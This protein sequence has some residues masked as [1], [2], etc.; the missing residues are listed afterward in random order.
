MP[1]DSTG[2]IKHLNDIALVFK[3]L[4]DIAQVCLCMRI[5]THWSCNLVLSNHWSC[6]VHVRATFI[7]AI[8][9]AW[10]RKAAVASGGSIDGDEV[11]DPNETPE[12]K[13]E[14]ERVRRQAN[15]SRERFVVDY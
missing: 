2:K 4:N 6:L 12:Q 11:I 8:W 15:N 9:F 3:H 14:R 7:Y 1:S 5:Y 10:N 13:M